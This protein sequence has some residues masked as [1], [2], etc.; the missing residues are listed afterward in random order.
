MSVTYLDA[1]PKNSQST[2]RA[3]CANESVYNR[4]EAFKQDLEFLKAIFDRD[5]DYAEIEATMTECGNDRK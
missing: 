4:Q 3:Y 5:I 2:K 1:Q